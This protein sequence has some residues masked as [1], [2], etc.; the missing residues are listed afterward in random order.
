MEVLQF[1]LYQLSVLYFTHKAASFSLPMSHSVTNNKHNH[2][3]YSDPLSVVICT[4]VCFRLP[5][6]CGIKPILML[7]TLKPLTTSWVCFI[8]FFPP[9][10]YCPV[11][12][13]CCL[14]KT[15]FIY[16]YPSFSVSRLRQTCFPFNKR[17]C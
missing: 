16:D 9:F 13:Q 8:F 15:V 2:F 14:L 7:L 3:C 17:H 1:F 6:M 11:H 5:T 12:F 4:P 10:F